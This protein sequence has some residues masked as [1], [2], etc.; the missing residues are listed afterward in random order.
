MTSLHKLSLFSPAKINLFLHITGKRADGYHDL[1]TVFRLLNWGDTLHFQVS[2]KLFNPHQDFTD[3]TLPITLD[4]TISVTTNLCDNLITKAALA[5]IHAVKANTQLFERIDRLPVIDIKLDKVLPTGAGLGG[6]SSNA[7]TTLLAL[8]KLWGLNL[9]QQALIDIGRNVGADV[10]IFIMG[11][12]AIAEGIGEKLTPLSL[13]PQHYLLLNP[14]AHA[15]TQALFAHPDLRRDIPAMS[16]CDI[17]ENS[18]GYLNQLYPPFSN[19][20][21]PVVTNLVPEVKQ[22]LTYLKKLESLTHSSARM[23]GTGSSVFLPIAETMTP[24]IQTYMTNNPP[25]CHALISE[26]LLLGQTGTKN[27]V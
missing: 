9:T 26:S 2:D 23:T 8:N 14:N 1:Q 5:L 11:Q 25:P 18:E 3:N 4:S 16:V 10:P 20:F 21:E 22:A 13:P 17:E 15:S 27:M 7:A 12:D 19:V 24:Q 6:G